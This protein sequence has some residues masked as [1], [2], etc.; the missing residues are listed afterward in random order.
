[1][2]AAPLQGASILKTRFVQRTVLH[3]LYYCTLSWW[4]GGTQLTVSQIHVPGIYFNLSRCI[5]L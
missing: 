5:H 2:A 4:I 1:M 3:L